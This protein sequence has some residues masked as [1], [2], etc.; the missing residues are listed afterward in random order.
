MYIR[1]KEGLSMIIAARRYGKPADPLAQTAPGLAARR[2]TS[3]C[4][5]NSH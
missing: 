5:T 4:N 2:I 3:G 1:D